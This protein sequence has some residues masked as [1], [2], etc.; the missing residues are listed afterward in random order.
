M[1]RP[2][3]LSGHCDFHLFKEG[4]KPLWEDDANKN[5]GKW[6]IRLRKGLASR[7][8]EYLV[9]FVVVCCDSVYPRAILFV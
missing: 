3:E 7:L 5:G 2:A 1:A 8:W 9:S 6:M 4:I